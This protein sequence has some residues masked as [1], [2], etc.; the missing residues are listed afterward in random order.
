VEA[1]K[2]VI[3]IGENISRRQSLGLWL[4]GERKANLIRMP[5]SNKNKKRSDP[6]RSVSS[7][8]FFVQIMRYANA[9]PIRHMTTKMPTIARVKGLATNRK[10]PLANEIKTSMPMSRYR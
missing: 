10:G 7:T 5:A 1:R 9:A 2:F 4:D 8:I 3:H 6:G